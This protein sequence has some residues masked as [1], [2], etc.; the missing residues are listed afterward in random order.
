MLAVIRPFLAKKIRERIFLIGQ[1]YDLLHSIVAPES[2]PPA[3]NVRAH[4]RCWDQANP[5]TLCL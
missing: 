2:L 1:D 5:I 3:F 4:A